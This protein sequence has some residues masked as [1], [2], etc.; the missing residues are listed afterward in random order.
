MKNSGSPND[1]PLDT[2]SPEIADQGK[3]TE[4]LTQDLFKNRSLSS[5]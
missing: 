1:A 5:V 4:K 2:K 3:N